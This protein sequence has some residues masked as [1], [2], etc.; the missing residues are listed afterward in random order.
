MGKEGI[1]ISCSGDI[2]K[3]SNC[4][5]DLLLIRGTKKTTIF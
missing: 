4:Q 1:A 5:K 3:R 2:W